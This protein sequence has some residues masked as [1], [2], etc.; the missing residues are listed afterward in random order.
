MCWDVDLLIAAALFA[1]SAALALK[2]YVT[3]RYL[4]EDGKQVSN[5]KHEPEMPGVMILVVVVVLPAY[6]ALMLVPVWDLNVLTA[7]VS[8]SAVDHQLANGLLHLLVH[9]CLE[10]GI[11]VMI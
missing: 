6:V 5:T 3:A 9:R 1:A 7:K 11:P 10:T 4:L 8:S 2:Q